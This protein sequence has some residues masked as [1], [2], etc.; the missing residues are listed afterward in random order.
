VD[1]ALARQMVGNARRSGT[2][3]SVS[4]NIRPDL[5]NVLPPQHGQEVGVAP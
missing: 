3:S 1:E 2:G 4:V 5:R